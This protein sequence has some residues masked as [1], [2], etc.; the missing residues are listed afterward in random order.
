M[1]RKKANGSSFDSLNDLRYGTED[2]H[3][4]NGA[5]TLK[6]GN[7]IPLLERSSEPK[8]HRDEETPG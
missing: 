3:Y 5:V 8:R 4:E 6:E 1:C 7:I 2:T